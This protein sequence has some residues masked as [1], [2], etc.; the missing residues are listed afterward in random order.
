MPNSFGSQGLIVA[1]QAE[2]VADYTA[3]FQTI[4]GSQINIGPE[5]PDGQMIM[6]PIQTAVDVLQLLLQVYNS[7]NPDSALGTSLDQRVAI[8]GISRKAGT[9]STVSITLV[10]SQSVNL[11]GLDQST[12]P[13]YTVADGAGIQYQLA[14]TQLGIGPG[15]SSLLFVAATPGALSPTPNT[16]T[17][18]VSI[19][20]GVTSINNPSAALS[21]GEDEESDADLRV[22]RAQSVSLSSQ[23]YYNGLLAAL[24]NVNG[25]TYAFIAENTGGT[26]DAN[27]VPGHSIWVITAGSGAAADIAQAIY[28]KRNA[29]CGMYNSGG[30]GAQSY[31]ITQADGTIFPVYWDSVVSQPLFYKFTATSLD[32]VTPPNIPAILG[33]LASLFVPGVA[34]QVN[35]NEAST[36]IQEIDANTLV[37]NAGFSN[38]L[39][40][41]ITLSG[42]PASGSFKLT[43]GGSSTAFINWNAAVGTIQTQ[44]QT[45]PGLGSATVAGSLASSSL[46]IALNGVTNPT[47]I[48]MSSNNLQTSAPAAITLSFVASG[49]SSKLSPTAKNNQLVTSS[50]NFIALPIYVTGS[51]V[52]VTVSGGVVVS[53]LTLTSLS[54]QTLAAVGGYGTRTYAFVSNVSG[55]TIGASTGV[56]V[57]GAVKGTD[58]VSVTD[59]L[60]NIGSISIVV[61]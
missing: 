21:I 38:G 26:V 3:G 34:A 2:L 19:V 33:S 18:P 35:I 43:Y 41:Y 32:G 45:L 16:I 7:F 22:R 9:F 48:G 50:P 37:T 10:L 20:L 42:T 6:I 11:Y 1:T 57:A 8:N 36:L 60:D 25:V 12:Q 46:T 17:I 4:Y 29:G 44:V 61:T 51:N 59:S 40:Q 58:I 54:S 39:T 27:G 53:S 28:T 23:G 52:V 56:Y 47:L 5:T 15:T 14:T 55:G 24:L 49:Y 31:N 30:A 13:V